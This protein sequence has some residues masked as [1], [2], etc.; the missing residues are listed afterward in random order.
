[1]TDIIQTYQPDIVFFENVENIDRDS[2]GGSN[3]DILK[4][5]WREEG[6]EC[7]VIH[8]DTLIFGL[9]QNRR[10]I[11]VVAVNARDP[12]LFSF[13]ERGV[14]KVFS[15]LESCLQ[16]CSRT[17]ECATKYMLPCEDEHVKAELERAKAEAESRVEKLSLIHIS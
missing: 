12:R 11:V 14:D 10:R 8:A 17:P 13:A 4:S 1:M 16:L 6:Y 5:H 3:L 15:T 9:P 7:Q 2:G